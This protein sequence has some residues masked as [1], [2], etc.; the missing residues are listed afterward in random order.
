MFGTDTTGAVPLVYSL[1]DIKTVI[2]YRDKLNYTADGTVLIAAGGLALV[3]GIVN[4]AHFHQQI[5]A[6]SGIAIVGLGLAA[7]GFWLTQQTVRHYHLGKTFRLEY[8]G[9]PTPK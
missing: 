9:F 6:Y 8:Y 5:S 2:R 4:S 1:N 7:L 3:I